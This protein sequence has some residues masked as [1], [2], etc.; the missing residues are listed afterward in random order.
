MQTMTLEP[1]TAPPLRLT[2]TRQQALRA[3]SAA[4]KIGQAIAGQRI[5]ERW[6]L[7]QAR[8]EKLEW[9]QRTTDVL[10]RL[11]NS[12]R[13]A[14]WCNDWVGRILPE[15]AELGAFIEQFEQEMEHRLGRL[16]KV[17]KKIEDIPDVSQ[18]VIPIRRTDGA[19]NEADLALAPTAEPASDQPAS[20]QPTSDQ[21]EEPTM[22]IASATPA[23]PSAAPQPPAAAPSVRLTG[24]ASAPPASQPAAGQGSCLLIGRHDQPA[25]QQAL[26][27][28][29]AQLEL[30]L[31]SMVGAAPEELDHARAGFAILL[32][33]PDGPDAFELGFCMGR[34][35]N[36]RL[37]IIHPPAD[38]A[39]GDRIARSTRGLPTIEF[40]AGEAWQLHLARQLRRGGVNID[41]NRLV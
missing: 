37:C 12:S 29:A 39:D 22:T 38:P 14:D 1:A 41:L 7:D 40:D 25:M 24:P 6:E 16:K 19:S 15:Y 3:V 21:S 30:P 23:Q 17:L 10:E 5:R 31:K 13:V 33:G 32:A 26:E 35:G 2:M 34:L 18:A 8:A 27:Q 28:F 11:F 4:I 36:K 9:V 20:D